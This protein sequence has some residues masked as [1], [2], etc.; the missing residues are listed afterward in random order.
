MYLLSNG[1]TT[2]NYETYISDALVF[3]FSITPL[4]VPMDDEFSI[5]VENQNYEDLVKDNI[6]KSIGKV[7]TK[8]KV[9]VKQAFVEHSK[10]KI[11]LEMFYEEYDMEI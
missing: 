4:T 5:I 10:L 6:Q 7:D 9:S 1:K 2:N 8:G 3:N 11:K